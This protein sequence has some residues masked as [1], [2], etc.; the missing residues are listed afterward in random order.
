MLERNRFSQN[1]ISPLFVFHFLFHAHCSLYDAYMR[2][3]N[4][5]KYKDHVLLKILHCL[6]ENKL[7][8][9]SLQYEKLLESPIWK[10]VPWCLF[11]SLEYMGGANEHRNVLELLMYMYKI[12]K[13]NWSKQ[14]RVQSCKIGLF[15]TDNHKFITWNY[16]CLS[17][18]IYIKPLKVQSMMHLMLNA[19]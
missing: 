9:S 10:D 15:C 16:H 11:I 7:L 4:K 19:Y 2:D 8:L 1:C 18:K 12:Y 3:F 5:V 13:N 17:H 6:K 14:R